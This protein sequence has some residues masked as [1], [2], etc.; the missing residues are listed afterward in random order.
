VHGQP[1]R[2]KAV[3]GFR[4]EDCSIVAPDAGQLNA[5]VFACELTGNE[6]IVTCRMGAEEAVVKMDKTF[7]IALDSPVGIKVDSAKICLF[8]A[9][10]GERLRGDM[11]GTA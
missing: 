8:D 10:T 5:S 1:P 11:R 3:L 6:T 7:D 4:P 9:R 2:E